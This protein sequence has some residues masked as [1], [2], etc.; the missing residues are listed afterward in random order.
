MPFFVFYII[1]T[2]RVVLVIKK[3]TMGGIFGK[4]IRKS[5]DSKDQIKLCSHEEKAKKTTE[6]SIVVFVHRKSFLL[7]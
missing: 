4:K 2:V 6:N 5:I 1:R 3:G 7:V